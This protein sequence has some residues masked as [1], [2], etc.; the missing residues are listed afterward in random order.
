[1]TVLGQF[2]LVGW[3]FDQGAASLCNCA[4]EVFYQHPWS[5]K[6][7]TFAVKLLPTRVRCLLNMDLLPYAHN[8][9]REFAMQALPMRCQPAFLGSVLA[10]G[11]KI[12]PAVVP[13]ET[14]LALLYHS[15]LS[16]IVLRMSGPTL[17]LHFAL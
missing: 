8:L 13:L 7:H 9:M 15:P 1:M 17:P 6:S 2:G 12:A 14:M 5:A 11:G 3:D 10:S 4:S 16:I